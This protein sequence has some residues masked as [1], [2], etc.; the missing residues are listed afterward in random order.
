MMSSMLINAPLP[1]L[2]IVPTSSLFPHEEHDSQRQ[3]PLVER[4]QRES[5]MINPPIV[6]PMDDSETHFVVLD[7]A[8]R[9]S[10]FSELGFPH[11]LVQV[12]P[13]TSE[14]VQL[15]TWHHVVCRWSIADFLDHLETL[16]GIERYDGGS[17]QA[18]GMASIQFRDDR[19]ITLATFSPEISERN[20]HLVE[21]VRLYQQRAVLQRTALIEPDSVWKSHPDGIALVVF[22]RYRPGD[23]IAAARAHAYIPPGITRHIV[24]G[25]AMRV[26]YPLEWL[27]DPLTPIEAK[28][29]QLR[30][31]SEAKIRD[32]AMRYYSE[33]TYV[34]DE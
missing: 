1:D 9:T 8:N 14:L 10:A 33:S 31:W 16:E 21:F 20:K 4:L 17:P 2:R 12:I 7:G 24:Q 19:L 32:R 27:R 15:E 3:R 26:N 18:S 5:V 29:Q 25:R 11:I 6:A 13:Y 34:Y 30:V 22:P 28:N 23:V